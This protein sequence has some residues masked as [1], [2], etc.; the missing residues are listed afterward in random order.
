MK[1]WLFAGLSLL[2]TGCGSE[3]AAQRGYVI[4]KTEEMAPLEEPSEMGQ[5]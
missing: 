3:Q 5:P 1:Q 4:S 2:L